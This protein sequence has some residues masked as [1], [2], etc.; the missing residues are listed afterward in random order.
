MRFHVVLA[1]GLLALSMH[2][3]AV[4]D[5]SGQALPVKN[6]RTV[7]ATVNGDPIFLDALLSELGPSADRTRLLQGLA[8][9]KELELLDRL[10]TVK[11]A[12]QEAATMGID[13][14]PEIRKQVEV[15]SRQILREVL[16][17]RLVKDVKPD[18]A[19]VEKVFRDLV[20][21]WKTTSLLF[22]DETAAKR[23][24]KE[25]ADGAAFKDAAARAV[26]VK[27]GKLDSDDA[28]HAKKDY[29]PQIAEALA[30]LKVGQVSPVIRLPSGF[31]VLSVV[32]IRYPANPEA[33]AAAQQ[34]V[35]RQQQVA[36]LKSHEQEMRRQYVA[37][38]KAV[39]KSLDYEA[40]KP[41]IDAM[42]KDKRVVAQIKGAPPLT[43]GE[44]TDYLR[45]Q[46]FHGTDQASQRRKMNAQKEEALEAT[47]GRR[48][49]NLE[50]Q[51]LG[52]DKTN[53]YRDRVKGY[54]E[55]LVFDAFVKKVILP[56]NKMREE[57]VKQYYNGHLKEY[58][59][60]GMLR[61]RS[62]AFSRRAAAE[63]AMRRLREGADFGWLASNA[64][65]QVDKGARGLLTFDGRPVT[66]DSMPEGVRKA[67]AGV[68]AG[69]S[70][71]YASPEG[72]F[73]VLAVQQVIAP[74]ARPY[75]EVREE[76]AK[77]L[78]DEKVKKSLE[79]YAGK[80]RAQS[81]VES[82]LKRMR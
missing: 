42:L 60:P 44:F 58:S 81:K 31:V 1:T 14:L 56:D 69:E 79:T 2:A 65:G 45:L 5:A 23:A 38:D 71:L 70:R 74:T 24:R 47:L 22:Q 50:A 73:Y 53:V 54:E 25:I 28:Y 17:E 55:S 7:L 26:A 35:L 16:V 10:I 49:L 37:V 52:I 11:L 34:Q 46:L 72:Y 18:P 32:D 75:D 41:G 80:L 21:E 68:K 40:A 67:L 77:K 9:A 8:T 78:Y 20:R 27:A 36:F 12:V 33:R 6:G 19:A 62:L 29:L 76:I 59:Y 43:V 66:T 64:A 48:L 63:D 51:R 13:E 30:G 82:Y 15:T 4:L 57:E 3:Q 61:T 39:L